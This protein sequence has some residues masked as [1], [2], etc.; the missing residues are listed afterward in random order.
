MSLRSLEAEI[1]KELRVVAKNS[2]L[3]QKDIREWRCG[4]MK[5]RDGEQ[6]YHLPKLNIDVAVAKGDK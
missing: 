1:L 3:R 2:R 4:E 6:V 5:E